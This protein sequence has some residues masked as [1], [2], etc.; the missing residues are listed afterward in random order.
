[1]RISWRGL[2]VV[3]AAALGGCEP[4]APP[5]P[6]APARETCARAGAGGDARLAACAAVL[7]SSEIGDEERVAVLATR[8]ELRR[9]EGDPTGALADFNAA[10]AI[11]VNAAPAL[12]GRAAVLLRSGQLDAAAAAIAAGESAGAEPARVHLLRGELAMRRGDPGG[13]I[14]ELDQAIALNGNASAAFAQRGMAK[15]AFEDFPAA[16]RDFDAALRLDARDPLARAGRC[17]NSVYLARDLAEARADAEAAIAAEPGMIQAHLC[18][19]LID[20]RMEDWAGARAAYEAA[21]AREPAN[22]A[23]LFGRGFARRELGE[24]GEGAADIRQAYVY[25]SEIDEK[26]ERLGVDF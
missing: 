17:W 18:L 15:Q 8:G 2:I 1:M 26:F 7:A 20:L 12:L 11:D 25:D 21:L 16:R 19:G 5:D 4:A 22:A 23:A 3:A 24:R 9:S 6:L 13:A 14:A 10:L